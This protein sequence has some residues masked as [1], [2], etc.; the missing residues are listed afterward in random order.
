[1]L[2]LVVAFRNYGMI[3]LLGPSDPNVVSRPQT[4]KLQIFWKFHDFTESNL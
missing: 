2:K 1:M 4:P 3:L